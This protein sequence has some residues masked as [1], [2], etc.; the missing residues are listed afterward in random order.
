MKPG[1]VDTRLGQ[2][3]NDASPV[4][5]YSRIADDFE[6][7]L[8]DDAAWRR[9]DVRQP[10]RGLLRERGEAVEFLVPMLAGLAVV[11]VGVLAQ[12]FGADSRVS[13]KDARKRWW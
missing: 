3:A 5:C 10:A 8:A 1:R 11:L 2:L 7:M 4:H 9:F 12:F 6:T 13:I